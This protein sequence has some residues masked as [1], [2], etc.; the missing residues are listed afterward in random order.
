MWLCASIKWNS[1]NRCADKSELRKK[2]NANL[3]QTWLFRPVFRDRKRKRSV[4]INHCSAK[5]KKRELKSR[6]IQGKKVGDNFTGSSMCF[7]FSCL[8]HGIAMIERIYNDIL[9]NFV[10]FITFDET[11]VNIEKCL[12]DTARE[13]GIQ[14]EKRTHAWKQCKTAKRVRRSSSSLNDI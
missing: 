14:R 13:H 6:K 8:F 12:Q 7:D 4:W 10:H 9:F 11:Y 1:T 5:W 3:N 2:L